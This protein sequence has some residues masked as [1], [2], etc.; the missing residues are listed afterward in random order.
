[1]SSARRSFPHVAD[2]AE[3]PRLAGAG[4]ELD[5]GV[6]GRGFDTQPHL[7]LLRGDP[8]R[9]RVLRPVRAAPR[10]DARE[11]GRIRLVLQPAGEP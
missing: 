1:M 4:R 2:L 7:H 6:M 5:Q 9:E 8:S 3:V 11:L 10:R